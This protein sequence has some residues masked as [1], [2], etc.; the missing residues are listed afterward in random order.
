MY[1][2]H[3]KRHLNV[4]FTESPIAQ[5]PRLGRVVRVSNP[6]FMQTQKCLTELKKLSCKLAF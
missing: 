6:T 2:V 1:F 3:E 4:F 5:L